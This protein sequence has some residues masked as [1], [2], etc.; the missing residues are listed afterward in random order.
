MNKKLA[1]YQAKRNFNKTTE[2]TGKKVQKLST[3][4]KIFSVQYHVARRPHYDFRLQWEDVLI[5]FAIPKGPSFNPK[6][7]YIIYGMLWYNTIWT[8]VVKIILNNI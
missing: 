3:K 7:K 6:D 5:S 4:K 8:I 1:K 2:P